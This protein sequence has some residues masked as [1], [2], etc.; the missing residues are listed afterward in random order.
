MAVAAASTPAY[1]WDLIL[2]H[3]TAARERYCFSKFMMEEMLGVFF[4]IF[5]WETTEQKKLECGI[6]DVP[7]YPH[8]VACVR[9]ISLYWEL[10]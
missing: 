5:C 2:S 10:L 3:S 7:A 4:L 1:S 9:I 8:F 6:R